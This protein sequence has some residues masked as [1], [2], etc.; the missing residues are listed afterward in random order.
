MAQVCHENM[1]F[2]IGKA[3]KKEVK[4][5]EKKEEKKEKKPKDLLET[6]DAALDKVDFM[7][8]LKKRF[9][10]PT[11]KIAIILVG[12]I[13]YFFCVMIDIQGA[14]LSDLFL[15]L[16]PIHQSM[17]AIEKGEKGDYKQWLSYWIAVGILKLVEH[18]P[19]S[20]FRFFPYYYAVKSLCIIWLSLFNGANFLFQS[21]IS[22]WI[23]SFDK[24]FRFFEP[25]K[26]E[27]KPADPPPPPK[28]I[29]TINNVGANRS[30]KPLFGIGKISYSH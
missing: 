14:L 8:D 30:S 3:E 18:F 2:R 4:K 29:E 12:S 23:P 25:I 17:K 27:K 1:S 21:I 24:V 10:L 5:E 22:T 28:K 20:L 16:Y 9:R 15:F 26:E 19:Y 11:S 7:V 13:L 6:L